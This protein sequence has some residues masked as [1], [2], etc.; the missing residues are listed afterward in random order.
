VSDSRRHL[1][2]S[3]IGRSVVIVATVAAAVATLAPATLADNGLEITTPYPSVSVAPGSDVSFDLA[4]ASTTQRQVSLEVSGVPSAWTATLH[5]GGFVVNGVQAGPDE[6]PDVRL[7]VKIPADATNGTTRLTI[8]A[9]AVGASDRLPI[10]ISVNTQAAGAVT[11][12]TDF[13]SLQG[14]S[15]TTFS[16]NLTLHN[17]TA[18]DLTF[19]LNA[20]GP[21][22]WV[23]SATPSSQAQAQSVEVKAGSS[24]AIKV[25][26]DPPSD[27]AAGSYPIDVTASSGDIQASGQLTVEI[28]GQY[29][30]QL[31]TPDG[32]LNGNGSAGSTA[33]LTLSLVNNGTAPLIEVKP[34]TSAPT[35]WD[36]KFDPETVATID[37]GQ[38]A[39]VVA[40]I[41]PSTA[42][43]AGDYVVTIRASGKSADG[44][45]TASA[46]AD[47]RFT[48]ETSP[49]WLIVGI[50]LIVLVFAGLA[51]VFQRYGRR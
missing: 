1:V 48:V 28:I 25:S 34:T 45:Q 51:F 3:R 44:Q 46:N 50:G 26:A 2:A 12:T 16:F 41:T 11:M 6:K 23:V 43:V 42:A 19:G 29:E 35:G 37:P 15:T 49:I 17:D 4:V 33:E 8:T 39:P 21:A 13:P 22:G 14:P 20:Q 24:Q 18:Q 40:R 31:T 5:G 36:I 10:A 47:I 9:T 38:S 27:V 32:R 30:L 7:D